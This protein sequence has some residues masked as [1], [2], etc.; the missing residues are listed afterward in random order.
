MKV[1]PDQSNIFEF[2]RK[3]KLEEKLDKISLQEMYL[4]YLKVEGYVPEID[5]D[6][7]IA[8]R[9]EGKHLYISVDEKDAEYF[10]IAFPNFWPIESKEERRR[11][12]KTAVAVSAEIKVAKTYVVNNN[13]T[14]SAEIFIKD[15]Q[16]F[17]FFFQRLINTI[18]RSL[19]IFQEKMN[20]ENEEEDE[21]ENNYDDFS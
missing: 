12:Y 3:N 15:P 11:I 1:S 17:K 13:V 16:D 7:D 5:E 21:D 6:G 10:R 14:I 9:Y 4:N 18:T 2:E 8:F 20:P 19:F